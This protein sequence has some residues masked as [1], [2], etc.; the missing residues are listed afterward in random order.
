MSQ[1][2]SG[3]TGLTSLD[4]SGFDTKNVTDMGAMFM[5]CSGLTSL[6]LS[7]FD[8]GN[9]GSMYYMFS[10]CASLTSLD[11]SGFN[12]EKVTTMQDMFAGCSQLAA[13]DLSSFKGS[14]VT[15]AANMF[16]GCTGLASVSL[17]QFDTP[18]LR[19]MGKM[20]YNCSALTALD[21]SSFDLKEMNFRRGVEGNQMFDYCSSLQTI[22]V[23]DNFE[24]KYGSN[25]F[26]GCHNLRGAIAFADGEDEVDKANYVTG[27]LT[28][29]VGT[30]GDDI[31][32]AV[33][34]PLTIETLVLDDSKAFVLE[35][36]CRV[37]NVSYTRPME[38]EWGTLCLP[39][40]INV[41]SGEST[42]Q[43]YNVS[44][45]GENSVTLERFEV[46]QIAPGYPVIVRKQNKEQ[47]SITHIDNN[48]GTLLV[49]SPM[50]SYRL[51]GTFATTEVPEDCYFLAKD[52]FRLV[53]DYKPVAAG[54]KLA[55]FRAYLQPQ[56]QTAERR[57]PVLNISVGGE[58]SGVDAAE[59]V[60]ALNNEGTEYYDLDGRRIPALRKGVNIVKT[61]DKVRKVIIK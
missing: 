36:N 54:V 25:M 39:Y 9:V 37:K 10:G 13:L 56:E 1:M 51:V 53:R 15:N 42:C 47:M 55:A 41:G 60:D 45:V 14:Q 24:L 49:T 17:S 57:A 27:Y 50:S 6:D 44:G 43:F 59:V 26:R 11:L 33:G 12:T 19:Y 31:V 18:K 46:G 28:K 58:A 61:G 32:G 4:L 34:N 48:L 30:N 20:F 2:F 22:Y 3:C 40:A 52:E 35:E 23:G 38:N 29:K 5:K 16:D 7:G 21:L 8:T